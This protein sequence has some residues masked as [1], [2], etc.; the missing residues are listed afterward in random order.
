VLEAGQI[1]ETYAI[2]GR[3]ERRNIDVVT[4]IADSLDQLAPKAVSHRTQI[5]FVTDRPGHDLRYAIDSIKIERDL[6]FT[7]AYDFD[8]GLRQTVQWYL[9]NEAW[10]R[11]I[12]DG[13]YTLERLGLDAKPTS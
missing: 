6:G 4:A 12:L 13:S 11:P 1:G 5:T 10:W 2:G 3:A 8:A 9:D 7:P